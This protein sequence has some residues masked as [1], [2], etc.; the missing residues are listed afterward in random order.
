MSAWHFWNT[1]GISHIVDRKLIG[2]WI[3]KWNCRHSICVQLRCHMSRSLCSVPRVYFSQLIISSR[4][5]ELLRA[6]LNIPRSITCRSRVNVKGCRWEF[7]GG[8]GPLYLCIYICAF[9]FVYLCICVFVYLYFNTRTDG[10]GSL[11]GGRTH[12]GRP[13]QSRVNRPE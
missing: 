10:G 2:G 4:S 7:C 13:G 11:V 12:L 1:V 6:F 5:K 9:V 3:P 8:G